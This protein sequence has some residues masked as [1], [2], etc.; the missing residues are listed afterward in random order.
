M[1]SEDV[2][3][4]LAELV[5]LVGGKVPV[6]RLAGEPQLRVSHLLEAHDVTEPR[7]V[8]F[9]AGWSG[10]GTAMACRQEEKRRSEEETRCM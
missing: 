5:H 9:A 10:G 8:G 6:L 4:A 3:K 7:D 1:K 2:V